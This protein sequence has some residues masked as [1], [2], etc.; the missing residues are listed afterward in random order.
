MGPAIERTVT[1]RKTDLSRHTGQVVGLARRGNVL[2]VASRGEELVA[3]IDARDYRLLRAVVAHHLLPFHPAPAS[4]QAL[5]PAGLGEDELDQAVRE[6]GESPQARWNRVVIAYLDGH[7][8]LARA[9][10]LLDISSLELAERFRRLEVPR[11]QGAETLE[12]AQSDTRTALS[13][14]GPGSR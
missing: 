5:V 1:I 2:I 10:T 6:A 14:L 11:R 13:W 7:I 9:A 12:E 4:D 3:V 8:S